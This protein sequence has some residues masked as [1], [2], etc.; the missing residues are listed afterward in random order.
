GSDRHY[1]FPVGHGTRASCPLRY[2]DVPPF[3]NHLSD[4]EMKQSPLYYRA[5]LFALRVE[6]GHGW[7]F[8]TTY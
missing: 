6:K 3:P 2:R 8:S 7:T 5:A 4:W 1:Y